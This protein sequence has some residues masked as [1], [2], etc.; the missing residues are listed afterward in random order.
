MDFPQYSIRKYSPVQLFAIPMIILVIALGIV[1]FTWMG[2]GLPVQP[3][4][5]FSGGIGVTIGTMDT[6]EQVREYFSAY[7]IESV[8][9]I[10]SGDGSS[11]LYLKFDTLEDDGYMALVSH[12]SDRYPD[13]KIDLIGE[14]FGQTLQN[15]SMLA[16]LFSFIGMAIVIFVIFRTFVPSLAVVVSAFADIVMTAGAMNILGI[17]L[18]L[19]TTAALLMLI[20]YSV[21]SDILLTTRVLKRKGVFDEK[22]TG[23]F[24]TGLIMT[25]TT[26]GA[27]AAMG[28]VAYIG[29]ITIIWE[30]SVVLLIGLAFDVMNTWLTNAGILKWYETHKKGRSSS[31]RRGGA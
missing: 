10:D 29:Q 25:T 24:R 17:P 20:G 6:P 8:Q 1:G 4:I 19:G 30:I 7:P 13:A 26:F 23:A 12:I 18:S 28:I 2:T 27:I 11:F 15:Q 5:D 3:G 22:I 21:D 9:G 16:L 31:G 14:S